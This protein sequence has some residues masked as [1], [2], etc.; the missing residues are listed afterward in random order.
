MQ[1]LKTHNAS[2]QVQKKVYPDSTWV[3]LQITSP[4][5]SCLV[6]TKQQT[7]ALISALQKSLN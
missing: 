7:Q 3:E 2:L 4:G 5:V 6:M 1:T